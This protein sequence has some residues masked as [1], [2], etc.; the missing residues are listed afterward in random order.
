[1]STDPAPHLVFS[2]QVISE[3]LPPKLPLLSVMQQLSGACRSACSSKNRTRHRADHRTGL[4]CW[5]HQVNVTAPFFS[6]LEVTGMLMVGFSTTGFRTNT[7]FG[8]FREMK[9]C[10]PSP[11][12]TGLHLFNFACSNFSSFP[13]TQ[14]AP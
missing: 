4:L 5:P 11:C 12:S 14:Q 6:A 9:I 7:W 2:S 3:F 10:P 13:H 1:M 8:E